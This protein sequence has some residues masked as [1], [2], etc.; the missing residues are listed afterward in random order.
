MHLERLLQVARC[1]CT[2]VTWPTCPHMPWNRHSAGEQCGIIVST[3]KPPAALTPCWVSANSFTPAV[4]RAQALAYFPAIRKQ[5]YGHHGQ[6]ERMWPFHSGITTCKTYKFQCIS[7]HYASSLFF[8]KNEA[9]KELKLM[10]FC[11][12]W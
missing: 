9:P 1:S 12:K 7:V 6:W 2:S 5:E 4:C 3:A 8:P 10:N 11:L